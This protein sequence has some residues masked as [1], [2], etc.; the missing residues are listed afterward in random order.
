MGETVQFPRARRR[1]P[2]PPSGEPTLSPAA[3]DLWR[4]VVLL[5][6]VRPGAVEALNLVAGR[7]V[8]HRHRQA[9]AELLPAP[10]LVA[11][12]RR[13]PGR[14]TIIKML[15]AKLAHL[16][17][18]GPAEGY[19]AEDIAVLRDAYEGHIRAVRA[20]MR[21]RRIQSVLSLALVGT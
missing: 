20:L 12:R 8:A 19:D 10:R 3:C 13:P 4:K 11:S 21:A 2:K 9:K 14:R 16:A 5:D 6:R 17:T 15:E 7:F 1:A 18:C